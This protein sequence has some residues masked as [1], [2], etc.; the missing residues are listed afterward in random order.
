M[1]LEQQ[2]SEFQQLFMWAAEPGRRPGRDRHRREGGPRGRGSAERRPADLAPWFGTTA[3]RPWLRLEPALAGVPL[4]EYFFF[5]RDRLSPAA[6]GARLSAPMQA[7][8]GRLQLSTVAQRRTAVDDATKVSPEEFTPLYDALLDRVRQK[9]DGDAV[10]S[11]IELAAKLPA[12]WP[13]LTAALGQIPAR[14]VPTKLPPQLVLL[15]RDRSEV[16]ALLDEWESSTAAGL[17]KAVKEARKV[18]S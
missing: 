3:V 9:P 14:D 6:P 2:Q 10:L 17:R 4:G 5:C 8:L 13:V 18:S 11:A 16:A 7:L 1:V 12:N 15:G